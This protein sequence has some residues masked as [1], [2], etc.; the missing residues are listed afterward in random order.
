MPFDIELAVLEDVNDGIELV[1]PTDELER[2]AAIVESPPFNKRV[3][4]S[5]RELLSKPLTAGPFDPP[6]GGLNLAVAGDMRTERR[7]A[8]DI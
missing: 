7:S 4:A 8:K 5:S 2:D 3:A 1:L 6:I